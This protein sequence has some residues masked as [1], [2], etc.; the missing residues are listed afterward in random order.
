LLDNHKIGNHILTLRKSSNLTQVELS[1]LVGVSHQAVSKWENGECL[2]DIEVLL[3]LAKV[4]NQSV[5]KLLLV[6]PASTKSNV[7]PDL[8]WEHVLEKLKEVISKP[9]FDVWLKPTS[10]HFEDG[11]YVIYS[12]N[13]FSTQ[14]LCNR[15]TPLITKTIEE[16]TGD[17]SFALEFRSLERSAYL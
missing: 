10:A 4:F 5:E 6:E 14:W 13:E 2:P 11:T 9:S 15:Y 1:N 12:P 16:I 3:K 8:I 17:S 7:K